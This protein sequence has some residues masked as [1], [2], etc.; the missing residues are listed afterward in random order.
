MKWILLLTLGWVTACGQ[1][2]KENTKTDKGPD[3]FNSKYVKL[4][5]DT[6]KMMLIQ[7]VVINYGDLYVEAD[8]ALLDKPNQT[9]TAFGIKKATFKGNEISK[10]EYNEKI[11]YTKGDAKFYRE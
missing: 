3:V 5:V 10:K 6:L 4:V 7:D 11:R 9:V 8:S 2:S 1:T